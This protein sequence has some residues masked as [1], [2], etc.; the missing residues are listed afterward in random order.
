MDNLSAVPLLIMLLFLLV[1]SAFFS[2][3]E[4]ALMAVNQLRLR[5]LAKKS[6]RSVRTVENIIKK[7]EKL[8]G[9]ILL[10]NNLV[11]VAMSAIATAVAISLWGD[12]GII[13]VT[14]V[15]T[16]AILLF[17]EITPKVY[18]KYYSE[19]VSLISAP[20][21]RVIMTIFNPFVR[22]IT[23]IAGKI[24]LITGIDISKAKRILV[25]ESDVKTLIQIGWEDGNI[26]ADERKIL[27]KIFTLN[28]KKVGEIMIP[29][30]HVISISSESSIDQ[31]IVKINKY[32]YTRFPIT[33]GKTSEIIGFLHAKDLIGKKGDEKIG[34]MKE[35]VR[36]TYYIPANKTIDSQLRSFKARKIHM[37]VVLDEEGTMAGL[38]TL[39]DILE[40]MVGSIEDEYDEDK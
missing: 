18:A 33:R 25:T 17:A 23:Y 12:N 7:P 5:Q 35:L 37:A 15:L 9:T 27:S 4:T 10:G 36:K 13:Y 16:L 21:L 26:T 28:D 34:T 1:C 6:P 38:L 8:I 40:Q 3:S 30:K 2:G 22:A 31:A 29:K 11:N 20:A 24:I 19:R 39:E 14:V 32:G